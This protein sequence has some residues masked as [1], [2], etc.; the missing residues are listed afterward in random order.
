MKQPLLKRL[1]GQEELSQKATQIFVDI[2]FFK[3][4]LAPAEQ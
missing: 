4:N 2:L 1:A 3:S